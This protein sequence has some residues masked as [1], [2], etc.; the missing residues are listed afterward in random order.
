M[1]EFEKKLQDVL[2]TKLQDT[3]II[4]AEFVHEF[5]D[6]HLPPQSLTIPKFVTEIER[7]GLAWCNIESLD[8]EKD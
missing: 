5:E 1:S 6:L 7:G 4:K 2:E 8:F 3:T